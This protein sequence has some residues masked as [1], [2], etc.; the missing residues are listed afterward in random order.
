MQSIDERLRSYM[1]FFGCW[2]LKDPPELL[3]RGSSGTVYRIWNQTSGGMLDAALKVIPIPRDET[4]MQQWLQ[5]AG[6]SEAGLRRRISEEYEYVMAEIRTLDTLKADSHIVCF[7]DY[8]IYKRS[9]TPLGWDVLIRMERLVTLEY[10][11]AH[12]DRYPHRRDL[13]LVL[14]IWDELLSGL[15]LCERNHVLHLDIKPENIFYA[16]PSKDYFKLGDFG[17]SIR[18]VK[19]VASKGTRVGTVD[20]MAPEMYNFEGS[21]NRSDMYSLAL[22]IYELLNKGRLPFMSASGADNPEERRKA[23]LR[24]ISGKESIPPIKGVDSA[25]MQIILKCLAFQPEDRYPDMQQMQNALRA[26]LYRPHPQPEARKGGMSKKR[27]LFVGAGAAGAL[28]LAVFALLWLFPSPEAEPEIVTA[29][30]SQDVPTPETDAPFTETDAPSA[31]TDAPS[32]ETDAPSAETDTP[33]AETDAPSAETD[34]PPVEPEPAPIDL[35][36][37]AELT[38]DEPQLVLESAQDVNV[39]LYYFKKGEPVEIDPR[40]KANEFRVNGRTTMDLRSNGLSEGD[41]CVLIYQ[42]A[43]GETQELSVTVGA[44]A[45]DQL[46]IEFDQARNVAGQEYPVVKGAYLSGTIAGKAKDF[47][48]RSW[49]LEEEEDGE[50]M[51]LQLNEAGEVSFSLFSEDCDIDEV[52]AVITLTASYPDGLGAS[53]WRSRS[54][55]WTMDTTAELAW[56]PVMVGDTKITFT[57]EAG[58]AVTVYRNG[59]QSGEAIYADEGGICTWESGAALAQDDEIS[60]HAMDVFGNER[61]EMVSVAAYRAGI[62]N[63]REGRVLGETAFVSGVA[64][65][66]SS[67][68]AIFVNGHGEATVIDD[69]VRA[70]AEDG[71]YSVR[72][73]A[74]ALAGDAAN[75]YGCHIEVGSEEDGYASTEQFDWMRTVSL[76]TEEA[77]TEDSAALI[78]STEPGAY[79]T[80]AAGDETVYEG[81]ADSD[82]ACSY[83]PADG[84]RLGEAYTITAMDSDPANGNRTNVLEI[85]VQEA[86]RAQITAEVTNAIELE[87][88]E[89]PVVNGDVIMV[90]GTAEPNTM[91]AVTWEAEKPFRIDV[92][93]DADG[94]FITPVPDDGSIGEAGV[95]AKLS[96]A[97]A[98]GKAAG[99]GCDLPELI[100]MWDATAELAWEPVMVGDTR[101]TFMT[102]AGA[103]VTVYRNGEQSGEAIYADEGGIC[104]WE[105]GAALAQDDEISVHAMDVFGNER[106]EM[107]SVAAYRAGIDNMREGRVLGETAFV[108][109]VARPGSSLKAIFVNGHGEATVID[110]DVRA[111]AEDGSY[112]VRAD[113]GALAGDAANL[114]GCH[115]EVG[116]EED[117]YA[118]TEQF[119]W[120]RTVSLWT[121]EALTED[122]AALIVSTEPGAYVTIA[123]GDETVYEGS[124]DSDGACSYAPADGFRLGE[125]YTITAMDSDPANGNRTNVLEIEV[126]EANRAQITAEVTNAIELEQQELP[127]VNGDVIMVEGTAEPNTMI[128]VTW[129]AEKPFR[130]DVLADA[131]GT[132]ITPVPDDGS[133]G[134]A[135]VTAKL[136]VAYADG[137]AAGKGCVLPELIW[138]TDREARLEVDSLMEY[139]RSITVHT[140]ANAR[141]TIA[142]D[143]ET[144]AEGLA[145]ADGLYIWDAEAELAADDLY[146][147]AC[148]DT[149]GN[150][151][152]MDVRVLQFSVRLEGLENGVLRKYSAALSG[153]AQPDSRLDVHLRVKGM[154][155]LLLDTLTTDHDGAFSAVYSGNALAQ[156][157][158]D[159]REVQFIIE[160]DGEQIATPAF[161]WNVS[162][163]LRITPEVLTEDSEE[164]RI[165]SE[166]GAEVTIVR[167][168]ATGAKATVYEGVLGDEG[169]CSY[170]PQTAFAGGESY[171]VLA[172]DPN[173]DKRSDALQTLKVQEAQRADVSVRIVG[174]AIA[175]DWSTA[176]VIEANGADAA[177]A[178]PAEAHPASVEGS[179]ARGSR[180]TVR[181][182]AEPGQEIAVRWMEQGAD[183][184]LLEERATVG[185]DGNYELVL[186]GTGLIGEMGR[187]G[188]IQ[189]CYADQKALSRQA[190][191]ESF[192]WTED[193]AIRLEVSKLTEGD[194]LLHVTTDPNALVEIYSRGR[195]ISAE[196]ARA[197]ADGSYRFEFDAEVPVDSRFV[198]EARD[199]FG[200]AASAEVKAEADSFAPITLEVEPSAYINASTEAL[201]IRGTAEPGAAL[202]L[203]LND[204]AYALSASADGEYG[205]RWLSDSLDG[206]PDGEITIRATYAEGHVYRA[207]GTAI[208]SV[209]RSVPVLDVDLSGI[210]V[211]TTQI[212]GATE[213][214]AKVALRINGNETVTTCGE[215]GFSFADIVLHDNDVVE[216]LAWDA[217]GNVSECMQ[218]VVGKQEAAGIF[219]ELQGSSLHV[220][221]WVV[222]DEVSELMLSVGGMSFQ[223]KYSLVDADDLAEVLEDRERE[224]GVRVNT[225]GK[226][227]IRIDEQV[228]DVSKLS[229]GTQQLDLIV[230]DFPEPRLLASAA[231]EMQASAAVVPNLPAV[232]EENHA[233]AF[234]LDDAQPMSS[235]GILL[236]GWYYGGTD[237][238]T[239]TV[240]EVR[241]V[242]TYADADTN[243]SDE[244]L[245]RTEAM[246]NSLMLN[247]DLQQGYAK[248]KRLDA[249][250]ACPAEY[251]TSLA[252]LAPT[253]NNAGFMIWIDEWDQL[254]DGDYKV[255]VAVL[256]GGRMYYPSAQLSI[257][258]GEPA[259][260][261]A[262]LTRIADEWNPQ[263]VS[264]IDNAAEQT[265]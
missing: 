260:T 155:Y 115:I 48:L 182:S 194:A 17:V 28:G 70:N 157:G 19:G 170:Q 192:V 177:R 230:D 205:W 154:E 82:G 264:P 237:H 30:V 42:D 200:N 7:E 148:E 246:P 231:F 175:E 254:E 181:G 16:E 203:Y 138:T 236:T 14:T 149:F 74:G 253:E 176:R 140:E 50:E 25:L 216:I 31:E 151:Q 245:W 35:A 242:E 195:R 186:D 208:L 121:E 89:L 61:E 159:G 143:G 94:T 92:L 241:L 247:G 103:A 97:Y 105:S 109:G 153:V 122:S 130:I 124:A 83:A 10:F 162:V 233:F 142:R 132:F 144:L 56:E 77:L 64:R 113:A 22:V 129:E 100:W 183:E 72:A 201:T 222:C 228:I 261:G 24:R 75:L 79:V 160:C 251:R 110:D 188:Q 189:V 164:L 104:T 250:E 150:R 20:Y 81:S 39:S 106:E 141:V 135:G 128:A 27:L 87:Q 184:A 54:V 196:G 193:D 49:K 139:S 179:I 32:A 33:S 180:L 126:Q 111:N 86:N 163:P 174:L 173:D 204:L 178:E 66:G 63:M 3:G 213:Q 65:P 214:N 190:S 73:D 198:V 169:S 67:L 263:P 161:T 223:P 84:F 167:T 252:Q 168:S 95:T 21:D 258:G 256:C 235:G 2:E 211:R 239:Y 6:G 227:C 44:S 243:A 71:S 127:V 259:I 234:G 134:E 136:S 76:W 199:V 112:S 257:R 55:L 226:Q 165:V 88:Q 60:V 43:A 101:I 123:A 147:V 62:D 68:K 218:T 98:D 52:G 59:E 220:S 172:R 212:S 229:A 99:K 13:K 187:T 41:V 5:E 145:D 36:I 117:G 18:N 221:G 1:P 118:S 248:L 146:H 215:E 191:S 206:L 125:A 244:I 207:S 156:Y 238:D 197:D 202:T 38:E 166:P 102:E 85:E 96:V 12:I 58:A 34:V 171:R 80:I 240:S 225:Q 23:S 78:V 37:R 210:S 114:Y 46:E 108:S 119:D 45:R 8:K 51:I 4:Q 9:D 116:S 185:P 120:M 40:Y 133:I 93:A 224:E 90:E 47:V 137:K 158:V 69:D 53:K 11:L 29:L 265:P 262:R 107:V 249:A 219:A 15:C 131:D 217:A 232:D 26:Y 152:A 57:T 209:D 91:I 255:V